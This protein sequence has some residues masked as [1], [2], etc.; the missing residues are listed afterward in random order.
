MK[1]ALKLRFR[2]RL[3]YL[4]LLVSPQNHIWV[5]TSSK[6]WS[7]LTQI[8]AGFHLEGGSLNLQQGYRKRHPPTL[9]TRIAVSDTD[10]D[11]KRHKYWGN[12]FPPVF[13]KSSFSDPC[14]KRWLQL[15]NFFRAVFRVKN[16]LPIVLNDSNFGNKK[17]LPFFKETKCCIWQQRIQILKINESNFKIYS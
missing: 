5:Q 1:L 15:A 12:S 3:S 8:W 13:W 16:E 2:N 17:G 9:D 14:Q 6:Y 4:G 11:T 10:T 7:S